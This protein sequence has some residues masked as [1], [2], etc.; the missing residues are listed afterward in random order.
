M[1]VALVP[2][3]RIASGVERL[4][5]TLDRL[6][7]RTQQPISPGDAEAEDVAPEE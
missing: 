1:V 3:K 6:L 2:L 7:L 4:S 5:S